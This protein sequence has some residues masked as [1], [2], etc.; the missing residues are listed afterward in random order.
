MDLEAF[1]EITR[2][3]IFEVSPQQKAENSR[4]NSSKNGGKDQTFDDIMFGN[5]SPKRT[6]QHS[7]NRKHNIKALRAKYKK[8]RDAD[9]SRSK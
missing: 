1:S 9:E 2:I 4:A 7:K 6:H 5:V 3:F 8:S